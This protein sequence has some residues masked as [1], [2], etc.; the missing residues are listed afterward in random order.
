M[1]KHKF[2]IYIIT[3][4]MF[5]TTI[6]MIYKINNSIKIDNILESLYQ[7]DIS[8]SLTKKDRETINQI[9][10]K[11]KSNLLLNKIKY[12]ECYD[13]YTKNNFKQSIS[14]LE[15]IELSLKSKKLNKEFLFEIK[16]LKYLNYIELE[17]DENIKK[18]L[19]EITDLCQNYMISEKFIDLAINTY[20]SLLE[21]ENGMEISSL[22][23]NE[24]ILYLDQ[25]ENPSKSVDALKSIG[26]IYM[27]KDQ[28]DIA[29]QYQIKALNIC[30][31][32]KLNTEKIDVLV[33]LSGNYILQENYEEAIKIIKEAC[34]ID[35]IDIVTEVDMLSYL[36]VAYIESGRYKETEHTLNSIIDKIELLDDDLKQANAMWTYIG[37][38]DLYTK[39]GDY[40]KTKDYLSK[41]TTLYNKYK[42]ISFLGTDANIELEYGDLYFKLG[43]YQKALE[44][45]QKS[46]N[47]SKEKNLENGLTVILKSIS[48]DYYK[49]GNSKK[50]YDILNE[51]NKMYDNQIKDTNKEKS[52]TAYKTVVL[53][54]KN[55]KIE[56]MSKNKAITNLIIIGLLVFAIFEYLNVKI[57][58]INKNKIKKLN[59][60][61]QEQS[62]KDQLTSLYNRRGLKDYIQNLE[63]RNNTEEN[64][65]IY[66]LDIDYFKQY[67]DNYG[68]LQG[69]QVLV[70]ISN[71]LKTVCKNEFVARYGGEEFIIIKKYINEYE[72]EELAKDI[73]NCV[74]N[75][76]IKHDYSL[77][78]NQVTVSI[79]ICIGKLDNT[80]ENMIYQADIA[81]YQSKDNG[82]NKYT[83][84]DKNN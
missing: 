22:L 10:K 77:V 1:N 8:T 56:K 49:L 28:L 66:M 20:S 30:N 37:Y 79:G 55:E 63:Y 38:A 43:E 3:I 57:I 25:I 45:H 40:E 70:S 6:V 13:M 14:N 24:A 53:E 60:K 51:I 68:H 84:V 21:L 52:E 31:D 19:Y 44:H 35:N 4:L 18:T 64:Y 54:T 36:S 76:N 32:N 27:L 16:K 58:K 73:Q 33:D 74:K 61:L 26:N 2:K 17:N 7:D 72:V 39:I 9:N 81:L 34:S 42:D 83:I 23:L 5:T 78:S 67:N 59:V 50:G 82:R 15:E 65:A 46:Y 80:F 48:E 62:I 71:C 29:L 12:I 69:D 47:L 11:Y 41:L 75:T